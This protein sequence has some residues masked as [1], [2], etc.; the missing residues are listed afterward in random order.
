M[1]VV[2]GDERAAG[3]VEVAG[4]WSP[5]PASVRR[6][7]GARTPPP[8]PPP[9]T[10][11][12]TSTGD[13]VYHLHQRPR[14]PPPPPEP[15]H[16]ATNSQ[17]L[18]PPPASGKSDAVT[19]PRSCGS[20]FELEHGTKAA[21]LLGPCPFEEKQD[22]SPSLDEATASI[23]NTTDSILQRTIRSEF[24]NCTVIM[25]AHR[26]PTVMDCTMVLA[27]SDGKLVEYD[28]PMELMKREGSLFGQLVKEYWSHY[29]SAESH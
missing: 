6:E 12:P 7:R 17:R 18:P 29:H 5:L 28:E 20:W 3:V 16:S 26:I 27:I 13:H 24:A 25:V 4:G 8:P 9:A 23:N 22:T 10:T 1:V 14:F 21:I 11:L 15:N 2:V 19:P